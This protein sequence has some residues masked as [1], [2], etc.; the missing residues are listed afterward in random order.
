[1]A[2]EKRVA[3]PEDN[4]R[5]ANWQQWI[6][7]VR[8]DAYEADEGPLEPEDLLALALAAFGGMV[9]RSAVEDSIRARSETGALRRYLAEL[10]EQAT[11]E[12]R[13]NVLLGVALRKQITDLEVQRRQDGELA[14]NARRE[15]ALLRREIAEERALRRLSE[16]RRQRPHDQAVLA[17]LAERKLEREKKGIAHVA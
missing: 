5:A 9:D 3:R 8:A 13:R 6:E 7:A 11:V 4:E 10:Q 1:M 16:S 14:E 15:I 2:E 12:R 17:K